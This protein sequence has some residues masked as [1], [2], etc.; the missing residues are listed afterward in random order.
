MI[1]SIHSN[2]KFLT[3]T[4]QI[5]A[6]V[7]SQSKAG[8]ELLEKE[9]VAQCVEMIKEQQASIE[10]IVPQDEVEKFSL[11]SVRFLRT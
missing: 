6:M 5:Q 3:F 11:G 7:A 10:A 1:G 2:I 8:A 4:E 9:W